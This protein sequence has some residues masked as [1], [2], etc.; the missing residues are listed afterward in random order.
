MARG[1]SSPRHLPHSEA[2]QRFIGPG[3][4]SRGGWLSSSA[5][6][7]RPGVQKVGG[8]ESGSFALCRRPG[9]GSLPP[10]IWPRFYRVWRWQDNSN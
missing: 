8:K 9:E 2:S 1:S 5:A 10:R 7:S 3:S 4:I 6:G